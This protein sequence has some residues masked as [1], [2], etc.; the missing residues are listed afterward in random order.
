MKLN[1]FKNNKKNQLIKEIQELK[2]AILK[3]SLIPRIRYQGF[4][5][6]DKKTKQALGGK[7]IP[8]FFVYLDEESVKQQLTKVAKN[9][10]KNYEIFPVDVI[11]TEERQE[12]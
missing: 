5:V 2:V 3:N 12:Q 9:L 1:P 10:Q 4:I 6:R 11:Y 8:G 7:N